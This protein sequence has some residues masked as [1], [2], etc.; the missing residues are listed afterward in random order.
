M[1]G[2][3]Q[4]GKTS[5]D[6]LLD[7]SYDGIQEY[8][9]PLPRWWVWI[10]W[11]S[12]LFA[13]LYITY[14][15]FG[16][17]MLEIDKY[18]AAMVAFFDN[19]AKELLAMGQID[20][21]LLDGLTD[22]AAMMK[23]AKKIFQSK[24][25][26]CHGVFGEGGIGPNLTDDYWIHG[27]LPTEV[28]TTV[29]DGVPSKGMLAWKRSLRPA[30]LLAVSSYVGTLLGSDPPNAKEPQG[31]EFIRP[32]TPIEASTDGADAVADDAAAEVDDKETAPTTS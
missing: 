15:H 6:H 8:D 23:G 19:Q 30:E 24:C 16:P 2:H 1:S 5:H 20:D 25:A 18:D 32:A 4:S 3:E 29:S 31:K 22:D 26:S 12:I 21:A 7:H 14:Y 17:G 28:Y 10:F 13:P 11:A 9:N 27:G